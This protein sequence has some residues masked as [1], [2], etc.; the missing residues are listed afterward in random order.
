[1]VVFAVAQV[2]LPRMT[3]A[4][5][6]VSYG[7][8]LHTLQSGTVG[9][10][11]DL[12]TFEDNINDLAS[13]NITWARFDLWPDVVAPTGTTT[14]INWD[15]SALSTYENAMQYVKSKGMKLYLDVGT[16]HFAWQYSMADYKNTT[17]QFFDYIAQ[18]T[19]IP[20]YVDAWQ[21]FNEP[22]Y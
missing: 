18:D 4:A 13:H 1:A 19:P 6:P 16:P 7:F 2:V 9:A 14:T 20:Q 15:Q 12:A 21:V 22:N 8:T 10:P 5:S 11:F 17:K 3:D